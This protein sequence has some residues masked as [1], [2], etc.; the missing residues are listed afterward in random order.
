[1][2]AIKEDLIHGS[3][4]HVNPTAQ[5]ITRIFMVSGLSAFT[6][7]Q[8][9]IEA[10]LA[11]DPTTGFTIP[12][13]NT[14][15]PDAPSLIVTDMDGQPEG[16]DIFRVVITYTYREYPPGPTAFL[17][18]YRGSLRQIPTRYDANNNQATITYTPSGGQPV[19]KVTKLVKYS[20][21]AVLSFRFLEK[22]DPENL[23]TAYAGMINSLA[24]RGYP[25]K[26]WLCLP[27]DGDTR[28]G[29]WY[30]NQ[31]SFSYRPET[32]DE[33]AIYEDADGHVPVGVANS[34]VTDGSTMSGNG[35]GRFTVQG[36]VDFNAVFPN[37]T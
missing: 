7:T 27:V 10:I 14:P 11:T 30:R 34:L 25:P 13:M 5:T 23:T 8:R 2:L 22:A 33:Y 17:K 35:W 15:H 31:Y 3:H 24:W 32:W 19:S 1:M 37:I 28:D 9:V 26:T 12:N 4:V 18:E 20:I 16:D 29:I 36:S 6:P 21:G